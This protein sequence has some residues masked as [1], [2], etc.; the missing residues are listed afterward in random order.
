MQTQ[1]STITPAE[2]TEQNLI[3]LQVEL[4]KL[5]SK[6]QLHR[7]LARE[8]SGSD[9]DFVS[10]MEINKIPIEFG[11]DV[12]VQIC[13]HKRCDVPKMIGLVRHHFKDSQKTADMLIACAEADLINYD[14]TA[15]QFI[16]EWG[17]SQDVQDELDRYQFPLPMV[18][19]PAH[20][21]KNTD[22]GYLIGSGSVVLKGNHTNDDVNLDHL[23]RVNQIPFSLDFE[24]AAM[25]K[26]QWKNLDKKKD[27]E[28]AFEFNARKRAFQKYDRVAH[29]VMLKITEHGNVHYMTHRYD[30]R[31]RTYC[32]GYHINFQG[33]SW[34]KSVICLADKE[35]VE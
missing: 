11:L 19:K 32:Q 13:L 6:N 9:P 20:L 16:V 27:G 17:I 14:S 10:H 7:R 30:K 1:T 23:N 33:N 15:Q 34:N 22:T 8:F 35:M 25:I 24:T 31:G 2:P 21:W 3:T 28:T 29:D 12:M 26:N 4:E 5:Y 18:I